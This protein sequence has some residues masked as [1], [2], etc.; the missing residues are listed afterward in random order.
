[1]LTPCILNSPTPTKSLCAVPSSCSTLEWHPWVLVALEGQGFLWEVL[2]RTLLCV[3]DAGGQGAPPG[4]CPGVG[5][6]VQ[7]LPVLGGPDSPKITSPTVMPQGQDGATF[8]P[9]RVVTGSGFPWVPG[10]TPRVWGRGCPTPHPQG[11][12]TLRLCLSGCTA[13]GTGSGWRRDVGCWM[14]L[15]CAPRAARERGGAP[16]GPGGG[17]GGVGPGSCC[18]PDPCPAPGRCPPPAPI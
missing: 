17:G 5:T 6:P 8:W 16:E 2:L 9:S 4:W 18:S 3:K 13:P 12:G 14:L 7:S 11:D 10:R 1:M 15:H